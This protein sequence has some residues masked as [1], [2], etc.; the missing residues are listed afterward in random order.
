M[1][2]NGIEV[3]DSVLFN[4]Y[5]TL[6]TSKLTFDEFRNITSEKYVPSDIDLGLFKCKVATKENNYL[7]FFS[8]LV[9]DLT[10]ERKKWEAAGIPDYCMD[11]EP[12]NS[13]E[14][15]AASYL[16]EYK[17]KGICYFRAVRN[18][19]PVAGYVIFRGLKIDF[20]IIVSTKLLIPYVL[21]NPQIYGLSSLSLHRPIAKK[22]KDSKLIFDYDNIADP[23]TKEIL[24]VKLG[25]TYVREEPVRN[26]F[27]RW[28][29]EQR[30]TF[31][32]SKLKEYYSTFDEARLDA[33]K[34]F[35]KNFKE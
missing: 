24:N 19:N 25:P 20:P 14:P 17:D 18:P 11:L 35:N 16:I 21:L 2:I 9:N 34:V 12:Y 31:T 5:L 6:D 3:T 8:N 26:E 10:S 4:S 1:K 23:E 32:Y 22:V 30:R 13:S 33:E 7:G 28:A 15:I 29:T 27:G